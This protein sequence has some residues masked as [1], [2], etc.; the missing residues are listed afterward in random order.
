MV[1]VATFEY[2][3]IR[4]RQTSS[5][6]WLIL[7]SAPATEINSWAGIP[8][9]KE[10]GSQETTGFQREEDP[11]RIKDLVEF[12]SNDKNVI[13]NPLLC[14]SRQTTQ[15][16]IRFEPDLDIDQSD[17]SQT[18]TL[19]IQSEL[20]EELRLLELLKKVQSDLE[21]R[22]PNLKAQEISDKLL[23]ELKQRTSFS[24]F[25]QYDE[26]SEEQNELEEEELNENVNDDASDEIE[27]TGSVFSDESHI[28]DFWEEVAARVQLLEELGHSFDDNSFL[29]YSKDAMISFLRPIVVVDGQ[30]RLKGAVDSTKFFVENPPYSEELEQKII[31]GIEPDVAQREIEAR[32]SRHLPV[33]LLVTDDPAEH[34]FQFVVVNQKATPIG[35]ALLGT[36]VSTSLSNEELERVS[37]RLEDSGIQLEESR[38]V[39]YF[40]RNPESPFF[41]LVERGLSSE[42]KDLLQ[43]S[44]FLPLVKMFRDLKG[45]K[46]YGEKND[47]ADRWKKAFLPSSEI[48][49]NYE[50]FREPYEYWKQLDGPWR[51]VFTEFWRAVKDKL[52]DSHDESANNYWGT[53][54]TSN[55]FNKVS[56]TILSADFF[57]Y[58]CE[59]RLG[60]KCADEVSSLVDDWLFDVNTSYFS[61]G[62]NLKGV[63]KDTPARR[64]QW[65]KLWTEYRKNPDKL[66]KTSQYRLEMK[67]S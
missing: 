42:N 27:I 46:I 62:W 33:S 13:Q 30:H 45:G 7:F 9:K 56:L 18:G 47:Y 65:A 63:R 24:L 53:P 12:Y 23:L 48:V 29:E 28:F 31:D 6:N 19:I 35:K 21:C 36:I 22:I 8:Q 4:I 11:K 25:S 54:K 66:P 1:N 17:F 26:N 58:L 20:L 60:I 38:S 61:R 2:R 40:T 39:A 10:I 52:A 44:V 15:E 50:G 3:A 59:R 32:I 14:A 5:G 16:I 34:V 43:W 41:G 37:K 55:I 64:R 51:N 49:A 67:D 57:Q